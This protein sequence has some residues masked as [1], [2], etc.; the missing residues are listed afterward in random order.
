MFSNTVGMHIAAC[1]IMAFCRPYLLK[2]ISP[3]EGFERGSKIS[4]RKFGINWFIT[5]A[6]ILILLHHTVLFYLEIFRFSAFFSTLLRVILSSAF[7][8]C[9]VIVTEY[10]FNP[11]KKN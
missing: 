2:M 10:L 7:T 11:V 4:I 8:L 9:L 6:G 1:T 5:Y 3:R